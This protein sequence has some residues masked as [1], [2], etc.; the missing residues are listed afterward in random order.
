[1]RQKLWYHIM[2]GLGFLLL[3][4]ATLFVALR[5]SRIPDE[6]ALHYDFWGK[7]TDW[8]GKSSLLGLLG[9]SWVM[10][11]ILAV[12]SFFPQTWNVPGRPAIRVASF[13]NFRPQSPRQ[14]QAAADMLALMRVELAALF[15]WLLFCTARGAGLGAWF[16]PGFFAALGLTLVIGLVRMVK[17]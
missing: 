12:V 7:P 14:L 2:T 17:T 9:S 6:V 13:G 5:W 15:A 11:I 1:M 4:G 3:L 8:S 10:Y 16:L